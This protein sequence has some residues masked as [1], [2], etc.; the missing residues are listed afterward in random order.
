MSKEEGCRALFEAVAA[1]A[2]KLDL[3]V[4][5]A[6][7][8]IKRQ[9]AR[10]FEW[11]LMEETFALNTF[12]AMMITSLCIPMLEKGEYLHPGDEPHA[13]KLLTAAACTYLSVSL[14]SLLNIGRWWAIL[15]R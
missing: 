3:L 13:R 8:L 15:R 12:S 10:E 5:N 6:G 7:G 1:K 11:Q 2:D 4:N 9:S 14:M